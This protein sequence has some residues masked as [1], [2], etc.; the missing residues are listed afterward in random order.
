MRWCSRQGLPEM[1]SSAF[2]NQTWLG[3]PPYRWRFSFIFQGLN[4][5]FLQQAKFDSRA[6]TLHANQLSEGVQ[7]KLQDLKHLKLELVYHIRPYFIGIFS[8]EALH[9]YLVGML[10]IKLITNIIQA[11]IDV[12]LNSSP[13][14]KVASLSSSCLLVKSQWSSESHFL[15]LVRYYSVHIYIYTHAYMH[16]HMRTCTHTQSDIHAYTHTHIHTYIHS[17]ICT[18]IHTNDVLIQNLHLVPWC[19]HDSPIFPTLF[20]W[21]SYDLF[22]RN[23]HREPWSVTW[24]SPPKSPKPW[25]SGT[26]LVPNGG[27]VAGN[28]LSSSEPSRYIYIYV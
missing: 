13:T 7:C 28:C 1:A 14:F 26:T 10:V 2:A 12:G 18:F 15:V 3:N 5:G 16:T 21:S 11:S 19:R 23:Y 27:L 6:G 20:Y 24:F 4:H 9:S 8:A 17:C 22:R 25:E